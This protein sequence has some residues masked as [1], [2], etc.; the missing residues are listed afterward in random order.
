MLK[1]KCQHECT[2]YIY[3]YIL[4]VLFTLSKIFQ[5]CKTHIFREKFA[6]ESVV[7]AT[8]LSIIFNTLYFI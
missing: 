7:I 4:V 1:P 5:L 2:Y 6:F 8:T 3:V